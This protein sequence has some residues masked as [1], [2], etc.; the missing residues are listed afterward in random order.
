MMRNHRA[1]AGSRFTEGRTSMQ[2]LFLALLLAVAP[3]PAGHSQKSGIEVGLLDCVI[4]GGT[5]FIFGSTKD[6][7]CTFEPADKQWAPEAYFGVVN[8]FGLDIGYTK[9]TM[10]RWA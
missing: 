9:A 5:G 3:I 8:K 4:E 1:K 7:S 2:K 6:L 10:M